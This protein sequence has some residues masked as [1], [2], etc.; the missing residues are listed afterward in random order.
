MPTSSNDMSERRF[1]RLVETLD[2]AVVW[3]FD[4]HRSIPS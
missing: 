3:E 4:A 1:R 2:H